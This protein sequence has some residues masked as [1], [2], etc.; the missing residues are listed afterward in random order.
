MKNQE[1]TKRQTPQNGTE[2]TPKPQKQQQQEQRRT[3]TPQNGTETTTKSQKPAPKQEQENQRSAPQNVG[4]KNKK[5]QKLNPGTGK[6]HTIGDLPESSNSKNEGDVKKIKDPD[7]TIPERRNDPV[8]GK[9]NDDY[10]RTRNTPGKTE[11]NEVG[12]FTEIDEMDRAEE[13]ESE[14]SDISDEERDEE[15]PGSFDP[16]RDHKE[17]FGGDKK[18]SVS[19]DERKNK[20]GL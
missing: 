17:A 20:N 9:D 2:T 4:D 16:E 3:Q 7:P 12:E 8:A 10:S 6:E 18:N 5:E 11:A 14:V 15:E 19:P 1:K 13:D